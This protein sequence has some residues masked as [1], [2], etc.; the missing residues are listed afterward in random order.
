MSVVKLIKYRSSIEFKR[1]GLRPGPWAVQGND[2]CVDDVVCCPDASLR[3]KF[4]FPHLLGILTGEFSY[5]G[6]SALIIR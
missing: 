3:L 6:P 5:L 2:D 4:S 1:Q